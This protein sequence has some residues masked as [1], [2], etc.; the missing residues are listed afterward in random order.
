MAFS[1]RSFDVQMKLYQ[2]KI[3]L[4]LAEIFEWFLGP[5]DCATLEVDRRPKSSIV[6]KYIYIWN[7]NSTL[8]QTN[9]NKQTK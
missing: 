1:T 8:M 5:A 4:V 9:Q 2:M 7:F 6:K 3:V